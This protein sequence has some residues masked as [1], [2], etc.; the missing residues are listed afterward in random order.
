MNLF[1]L[2]VGLVY[3]PKDVTVRSNRLP[4][5]YKMKNVRALC[6]IFVVSFVVHVDAL[7]AVLFSAEDATLNSHS[8]Q[9]V[10]HECGNKHN[11]TVA[12]GST[13]QPI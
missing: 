1:E 2:I 5:G 6:Q 7:T 4:S 9:E 3:S 10:T 13:L 12:S 8:M 11:N